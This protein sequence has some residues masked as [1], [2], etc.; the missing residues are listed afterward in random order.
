MTDVVC[1]ACGEP[2]SP[3][4]EFCGAC[5]A[6]LAWDGR[7]DADRTQRIDPRVAAAISVRLAAQ[8]PGP[9]PLA[10]PSPHPP[11]GDHAYRIVQPPGRSAPPGPP[12]PE[13]RRDPAELLGVTV[14]PT[15]VDVLPTGEPVEVAVVIGNRSD[16][17]DGYTADV[18]SRPPW[19]SA[20]GAEVRLLPG[21]EETIRVVFSLAPGTMIP[22]QQI[23]VP[24]RVRSASHPAIEITSLVT[25]V[26]PVLDGT[27]LIRL[28]PQVI[29]VRDAGTGAASVTIENRGANKPT[30]VTFGG[31]DPELAVG[32][33]FAP[34]VLDVPPHGSV[35]AQLHVRAPTPAPGQETSRAFTVTVREGARS[36]EAQ[37]TFV[38]SSSALVVDPPVELRLEPSVVKVRD[39]TR[40]E[41]LLVA[42]NRRGRRPARLTLTGRDPERLVRFDFDPQVLVIPPGQTAAARVRVQAPP[43]ELGTEATRAL[44]ITGTDPDPAHA[45]VQIAGSFLQS[46]SPAVVDPPVQLRL[47]PE[48]VRI[49]GSGAGRT[50][51]SIDNRGGRLPTRVALSAHDPE[52][53]LRVDFQ[54]PVVDIAPGSWAYVQLRVTSPRPEGGQAA[55][56]PFVVVASDHDSSVECSGTVVHTAGDPR[57]WV[58]MSLVVLGAALMVAGVF[59]PWLVGFDQ[60]GAQWTVE[61]FIAYSSIDASLN[62]G[63][64]RPLP[65]FLTSGGLVITLLA[66]LTL[67]GLTGSK[68]RL[69]RLATLLGL[70]AIIAFVLAFHLFRRSDLPGSGMPAIGAIL[71]V[72]GCAIA[73]V[74]SLVRRR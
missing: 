37:G 64:V 11:D 51:L 61:R 42:D 56:R 18:P 23:R 52:G 41:L 25:V 17:V 2:N 14:T 26:V 20:V 57:P 35:T 39:A 21:T 10:Q 68:G 7:P 3:D 72:L 31:A 38:Q 12:A 74:G 1:D 62:F 5:R 19:L 50:T 43:P 46:S 34:P 30:R 9:G 67:F 4:A 65:E 44:T 40:A 27:L 22:A 71:I 54:P 69:I 15:S 60:T 47:D 8:Q 59:L 70:L 13:P 16:I 6:F 58:R 66:A 45:P 63:T 32:F 36:A 28:E 55:S 73:F 48:V 49:S 29:R 53:L 24:L 33:A